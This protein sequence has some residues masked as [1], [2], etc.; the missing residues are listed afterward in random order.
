MSAGD[1]AINY[2]SMIL[3]GLLGLGM[4]LFVYR[5]TMARAEELALEEGVLVPDGRDGGA[6]EYADALPEEMMDPD[7]AALR[8]D[9]DDISLWEAEELELA[10]NE[11]RDNG[12][13]GNGHVD[14]KDGV[15]DDESREAGA[16][17]QNGRK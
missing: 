10:G 1:K 6:S 14:G 13:G 5:R 15:G 3:G 12:G 8:M 2:T 17:L 7:A 16:E 4:G 11:Y 9:D